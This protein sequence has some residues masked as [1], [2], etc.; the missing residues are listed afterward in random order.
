MVNPIEQCREWAKGIR[1]VK[2]FQGL[3]PFNLI[4]FEY[5]CQ[6]IYN[7]QN[8]LKRAAEAQKQIDRLKADIKALKEMAEAKQKMIEDLEDEIKYF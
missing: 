5:T 2:D 6:P 1:Y 3:N 8:G 4:P 7:Q